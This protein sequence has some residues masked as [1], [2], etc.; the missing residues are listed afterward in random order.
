[1]RV[2]SPLSLRIFWM[3]IAETRR[4]SSANS[5]ATRLQP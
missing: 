4:L 5:A 2:P 1:M 3:V